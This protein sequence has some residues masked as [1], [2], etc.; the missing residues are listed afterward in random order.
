[1]QF[2]NTKHG[3]LDQVTEHLNA[4]TGFLPVMHDSHKVIG[5]LHKKYPWVAQRSQR[6]TI[7]ILFS[8]SSNIAQVFC[9]KRKRFNNFYLLLI[10]GY[11]VA[12]GRFELPTKGL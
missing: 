8:I 3:I 9:S 5:C 7:C 11:M 4:K 6:L 1:L 12:A 10:G 2:I